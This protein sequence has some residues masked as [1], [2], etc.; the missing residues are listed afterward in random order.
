MVHLYP[1]LKIWEPLILPTKQPVSFKAPS[2]HPRRFVSSNTKS[3]PQFRWL[4]I[5]VLTAAAVGAGVYIRSQY[6]PENGTL[7]P[8]GFTKFELV[9]KIPTSSTC[10]LFTLRP[11]REGNNWE[12]YQMAWQKGLWSV[13]FK[14][15]QLQI[16]RDYTP[17]PPLSSNTVHEDAWDEVDEVDGT[18]KFLIRRDPGGEVSGY[19]HNLEPG[20]T[21]DVRGPQMDFELPADIQE[22]LFIAGGTGIAP[23]LQTAH[24]LFRAR[25]GDV[26][27]RMH[28]IWANRR[29]EDCLGG[30]SDLYNSLTSSWWSRIITFLTG[31]PK[32]EQQIVS[33][34]T[35]N[36]TVAQLEDFKAQYPG[37]FTVDYFVDEENILINKDSIRKFTDSATPPLPGGFARRRKKLILISGPDG[38]ISYLAGPKVWQDGKEAQ[39]PMQGLLRQLDLKDWIVWKL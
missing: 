27:T 2:S 16:G 12:V 4:R 28:I 26:R 24:T 39:G 31:K 9:S 33:A 8:V 14:Q 17:L 30:R 23:A 32:N 7:N 6:G 1:R 10:S 35:P 36:I 38:F 3:R 22:V 29:R 34:Q 13:Q 18:L 21:V 11:L 37:Q 5:T 20:S 15:P 25:G 19:L